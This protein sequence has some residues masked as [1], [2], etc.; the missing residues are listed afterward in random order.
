MSGGNSGKGKGGEEAGCPGRAAVYRGDAVAPRSGNRCARHLAQRNGLTADQ[1]A[2]SSF[3]ESHCGKVSIGFQGEFYA[4]AAHHS[5][6]R[7]HAQ[8]QPAG[9]FIALHSASVQPRGIRPAPLHTD[10]LEGS[11]RLHHEPATRTP[12]KMNER[13]RARARDEVVAREHRAFASQGDFSPARENDVGLTG[14]GPHFD[15]KSV[16]SGGGCDYAEGKQMHAENQDLESGHVI[17][18]EKR[19]SGRPLSFL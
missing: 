13:P 5:C 15:E 3:F 11:V 8:V 18:V 17:P 12:P 6:R 2:H 1:Q 14:Y 9:R 16:F 4:L 19:L 7:H 10:Q